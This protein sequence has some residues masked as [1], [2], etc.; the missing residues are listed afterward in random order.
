MTAFLLASLRRVIASRWVF[1]GYR[2]VEGLRLEAT[3]IDFQHG[4]GPIVS[5]SGEALLLALAGRRAMLDDLDGEG[6]AL[7][8]ARA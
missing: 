2:R 7:L 4:V 1:G 5:G 6:L 3:D 8:E